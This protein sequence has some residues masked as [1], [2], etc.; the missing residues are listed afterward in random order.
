M[1]VRV[2]PDLK[3]L[4]KA[5]R[6]YNKASDATTSREEEA[7]LPSA[8]VFHNFYDARKAELTAMNA[9]PRSAEE[10]RTDRILRTRDSSGRARA[11][12]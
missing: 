12:R 2:A 11:R 9:Q 1:A 6:E 10:A 3:A 8:G 7:A 4:A 5:K